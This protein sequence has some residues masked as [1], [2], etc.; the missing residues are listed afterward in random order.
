MFPPKCLYVPGTL[1]KYLYSRYEIQAKPGFK[2]QL[3]LLL[4]VGSQQIRLPLCT[5]VVS[6]V[7]RDNTY[8]TE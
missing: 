7:N 3:Q 8:F 4:V 5:M 6:S 1:H 2:S